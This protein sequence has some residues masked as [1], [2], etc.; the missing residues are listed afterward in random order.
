MSDQ[1]LLTI[2]TFAIMLE[3][4]TIMRDVI[5]TMDESGEPYVREASFISRLHRYIQGQSKEK[6]KQLRTA[7]STDN[8][9]A[10]HILVD[11][12]EFGGESRLIFDRSVIGVF[13][14]FDRS[15]F[16]DLTDVALKIQLGV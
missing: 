13:R 16:Q 2:P 7:F 12:D 9:L 8:L 5:R 11:K 1:R 6:Q 14:L 3:H 10:S 4:H 15:L